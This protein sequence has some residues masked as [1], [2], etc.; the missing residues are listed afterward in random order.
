MQ[1][2]NFSIIFEYIKFSSSLCEK[3]F[4]FTLLTSLEEKEEIDCS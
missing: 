4:F 2:Y 1:F 3:K